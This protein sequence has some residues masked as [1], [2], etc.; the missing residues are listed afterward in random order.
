[1]T[2]DDRAFELSLIIA[3]NGMTGPRKHAEIAR[4]I[5]EEENAIIERCAL[6]GETSKGYPTNVSERIRALKH[7][8]TTD[9]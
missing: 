8:E 7:K 2:P 6:L 9:D 1:M 4:V 3:A 5:R